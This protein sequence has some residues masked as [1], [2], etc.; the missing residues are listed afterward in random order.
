MF[1]V[2]RKSVHFLGLSVPVLYYFTSREVTLIFVG[3]AGVCAFLIEAARLKW[4]K[5][6]LFI[7]K[8]I[9]G[10]TREHEQ[11]RVTGATYFCVA[12]FVAVALFSEKVAV[13]SLLFLTF[14][15]SVAAL[16]GTRFGHHKLYGKSAEGSLACFI[17]CGII[18]WFF[19]E[20]V[21]LLGAAAATVI[22]LLPVP[23]DD[24][25]RIPLVSGGLMQ[26]LCF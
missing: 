26:L 18:G 17:T 7:F 19:L 4:P 12:A 8:I 22:E 24:N 3:I 16:V 15:D 21:G 10:Y 6:N 20:W 2:K 11:A 25:L 9:G 23:V 14:G 1:E 5:V 13:S